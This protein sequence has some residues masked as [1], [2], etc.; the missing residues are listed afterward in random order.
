MS[1]YARQAYWENEILQADPLQL[2]RILYRSALEAVRKASVHLREGDI[3][4]RS[5]QI[6]KAGEILNELAMSVNLEQGG[7]IARNL[8]ELYDYMQRLLQEANFR[9]VEPPLAELENLLGTLLDAW[10]RCR[11]D[12]AEWAPGAGAGMRLGAQGDEASLAALHAATASDS[13][14]AMTFDHEPVSYSPRSLTA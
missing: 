2:V 4:A 9:Q 7:D 10:E 14:L 3:R 11:P 1:I 13:A 12:P 6:T 8:I 5:A